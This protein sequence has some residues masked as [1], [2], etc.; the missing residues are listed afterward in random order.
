MVQH[1][2]VGLTLSVGQTRLAKGLGV[3]GDSTSQV[4]YTK[5]PPIGDSRG[6]KSQLYQD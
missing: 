6:E 5:G 4:E 3:E 1:M 2:D